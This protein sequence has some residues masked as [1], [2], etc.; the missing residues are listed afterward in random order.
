MCDSAVFYVCSLCNR[1]L[2][3]FKFEFHNKIAASTVLLLSRNN[4]LAVTVL[5]YFCGISMFIF[6][7]GSCKC[8][9]FLV[10]KASTLKFKIFN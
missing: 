7:C 2:L 9:K 1:Q 10:K 5:K 6:M 3:Y 4:I 8:L